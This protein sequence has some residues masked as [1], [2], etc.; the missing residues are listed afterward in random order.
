MVEAQVRRSLWHQ[1]WMSTSLDAMIGRFV[2]LR[3]AP[4]RWQIPGA[5]R[6]RLVRSFERQVRLLL[7]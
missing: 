3:A 7:L 4:T 2:L 5:A 1:Q 6:E